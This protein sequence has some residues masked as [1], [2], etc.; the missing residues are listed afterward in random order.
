MPTSNSRTPHRPARVRPR[1]ADRSP[2]ELAMMPA[3]LVL[4][5]APTE[6]ATPRT[7]SVR[8]KRPVP[9][10]MSAATSVIITPVYHPVMLAEEIATLDVVTEGRLIFGAGI[11]YRPDEFEYLDRKSVV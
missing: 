9:R 6:I 3:K 2:N 5:E 11:G 7:P 8:L 10:V 1:N 4:S